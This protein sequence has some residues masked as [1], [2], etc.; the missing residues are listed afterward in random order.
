MDEGG[1][2]PMNLLTGLSPEQEELVKR[3]GAVKHYAAGDVIF[4]EGDP[5]EGL[6][7]ILAGA[8]EIFRTDSGGQDH[9]LNLLGDGGILGEMGLL[10][11]IERRTA[12]ARAAEPTELLFLDGNPIKALKRVGSPEASLTLFK[13]LA[14]L[15]GDRLG[16]KDR[17]IQPIVVDP[18]SNYHGQKSSPSGAMHVIED[19]LPGGPLR[20]FLHQRVLK[21]GT[22]LFHYFD[23]VDGFYLLTTGEMEAVLERGEHVRPLGRI[24]APALI[25]EVAFFARRAR[26]AS[27]RATEESKVAHFT[28]AAFEKLEKNDPERAANVLF[29]VVE[30]MVSRI[31]QREN[32]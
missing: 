26:S 2:T 22:F 4:H 18:V 14:C 29:A 25:G 17:G 1:P 28:K 23:E 12:S 7:V 13:N 19:A 32:E 24:Q 21:P 11:D 3:S 6:F 30:L 31:V 20:S 16:E 8:I 15:L 9:R 27:I 10:T 5:A